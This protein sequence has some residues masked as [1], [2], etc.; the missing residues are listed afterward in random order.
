MFNK[1]TKAMLGVAMVTT[2][3]KAIEQETIDLA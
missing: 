1:D 3:L 2:V